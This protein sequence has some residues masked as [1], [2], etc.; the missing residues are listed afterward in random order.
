MSLF[1][2]G[3]EEKVAAVEAAPPVILQQEN[4]KQELVIQEVAHREA[5]FAQEDQK[6][7]AWNQE[8]VAKQEEKYADNEREA[9]QEEV[10]DAKHELLHVPAPE[11]HVV[12][13]VQQKAIS[14]QEEPLKK[15]L[16]KEEPPKKEL[17]KIEPTKNGAIR[18]KMKNVTINVYQQSSTGSGS[19]EDNEM[20]N[21]TIN[22]YLQCNVNGK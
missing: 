10:P 19:S 5:E 3:A 6:L 9:Q 18:N 7:E 21:V 12:K 2:L 8:A 17:A 4:V 20:E 22:V 1:L 13:H 15:E 16:A 14:Q 11:L